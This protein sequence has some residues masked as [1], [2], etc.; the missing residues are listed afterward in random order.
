MRSILL[1]WN[2]EGTLHWEWTSKG[3]FKELSWNSSSGSL[4]MKRKWGGASLKPQLSDEQRSTPQVE[5]RNEFS[6]WVPNCRSQIDITKNPPILVTAKMFILTFVPIFDTQGQFWAISKG[7]NLLYLY[8]E[9]HALLITYL[10][11]LGQMSVSV[12]VQSRFGI[13]TKSNC[14][15][16]KTNFIF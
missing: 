8:S 1:H 11:D 13:G 4:F 12:M 9:I 3:G 15:Y 5:L 16:K 14:I 10:E 6:C 7:S 2:F